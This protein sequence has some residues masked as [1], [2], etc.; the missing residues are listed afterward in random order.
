MSSQLPILFRPLAYEDK[1]FVFNSWLKSFRN[2]MFCKNVDN[3]IYFLNH[4]KIV[5]SCTLKGKTVICCNADD[6]KTIYGY[7]CYEE[8]EGQFV[9]HFIYVK[10]LY[11][12][13][14]IGKQLLAQTGH[15]FGTLGCYTHQTIVG[16]MNE[17]KYNLVYHPYLLF[18][19]G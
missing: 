14:G 4:H 17:E 1:A 13:L 10:N 11:R 3:T 19:R 5:D 18:N 7:I 2:G 15:D 8:I 9:L 16:A 6:P 12:K